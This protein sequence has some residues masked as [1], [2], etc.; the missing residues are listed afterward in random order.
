[1]KEISRA[2]LIQKY[3]VSRKYMDTLMKNKEIPHEFKNGKY[4]FSEETANAIIEEYNYKKNAYTLN[5][6]FNKFG[7]SHSISLKNMLMKC[8][9]YRI[10]DDRLFFEKKSIDDYMIQPENYQIKK[11]LIGDRQYFYMEGDW[12][13]EIIKNYYP[14]TEFFDFYENKYGISIRRN[15]EEL[16]DYIDVE[17]M[18]FFGT[19]MHFIS[20]TIDLDELAKAYYA[21]AIL[22]KEKNP[23]RKYEM[24]LEEIS[25]FDKYRLKNTIAYYKEYMWNRLHAAKSNQLRIVRSGFKGLKDLIPLLNK[26]IYELDKFELEQL[27][28]SDNMKYTNQKHIAAFINFL[29]KNYSDIWKFQIHLTVDYERRVKSEVDFYTAE[30][31]T[32]YINFVFDV[33]LHIEKAFE[34]YAYAR[35]WLYSM[36][37]F[38]LAWRKCDILDIP[39]LDNIIDASKYTLQWFE[40]NT[41]TMADAAHIVNNTKLMTE[42]FLVKKTENKKHFI[43]AN[44]FL[45]PTAIGIVICQQWCIAM[46]SKKL[47][48]KMNNYSEEIQRKLGAG[49]KGLTTLKANRTLLTLCNDTA[50]NMIDYSNTA[51]NITSYMRSHKKN[52][53][54]FSDTTSIYLKSVYDD[55]EITKIPMQMAKTGMFGWLY[56]E[57]LDI[58]DEDFE[59]KNQKINT[60]EILRKQFPKTEMEKYVGYIQKE[61]R[62][63]DSVINELLQCD[64]DELKELM[65]DLLAGRK[66][67]GTENIYCLKSPECVNRTYE[68]CELCKYS[69]PT[70]HALMVIGQEVLEIIEKLKE[71]EIEYKADR[72]RYTHQ[73]L[74]LVTT[75]KEA[76]N[77]FGADYVAEYIPY[78]E[79]KEKLDEV[80]YDKFL[81]KKEDANE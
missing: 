11:Y 29:Q 27:L 15:K 2:E 8:F 68:G 46:K 65:N 5:E 75:I 9:P 73:I 7:T 81:L 54:D 56:D 80:K 20:K 24:L 53:N 41:F 25:E 31:W 17:E 10:Y 64:K 66:F 61:Q 45:I 60:I 74:R 77:Q 43:I 55:Y 76:V 70:I 23:Y 28:Q 63:R 72:L 67:S 62:M 26:E 50:A 44:G 19:N 37:L 12:E 13:S 33:D 78:I 47:F 69:I 49:V 58:I 18:K 42:Q 52:V 30:E 6:T 57:L 21:D 40:E 22:I 71:T 36:L 51:V 35:S 79:I 39:S 38:S 1:M 59:G 34:N 32:A 16:D 4:Y 48:G 3:H 14:I